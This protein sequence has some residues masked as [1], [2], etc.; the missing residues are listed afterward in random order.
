MP[1]SLNV[2][3]VDPAVK[4]DLVRTFRRAKVEHALTNSFGFGGSNASL[5]LGAAR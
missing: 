5:I 3:E 4:F 1:A 2:R